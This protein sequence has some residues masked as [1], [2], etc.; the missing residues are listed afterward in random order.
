MHCVP[1]PCLRGA[2]QREQGNVERGYPLCPGKEI[3][4][5]FLF[6]TLSSS[7]SRSPVTVRA[8]RIDPYYLAGLS[9]RPNRPNPRDT[10]FSQKCR[11]SPNASSRSCSPSRSAPNSPTRTLS[12][13]S[14]PFAPF[15]TFL[16]FRPADH[17]LIFAGNQLQIRSPNSREGYVSTFVFVSGKSAEVR[18]RLSDYSMTTPLAGDGSNYPCKVRTS[19]LVT[20]LPLTLRFDRVTP[21]LRKLPLSIP[22]RLSPPVLNLACAPSF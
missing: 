3:E 22:S 14:L 15:F 5:F 11:L 7:L 6:A 9:K 19:S 17:I 20:V 8:R 18:S 4:A 21:L 16:A 1:I 13:S 12:C 2:V 10:P